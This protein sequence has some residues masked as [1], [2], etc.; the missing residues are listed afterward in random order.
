MT[1]GET[2]MS[3]GH[4]PAAAVSGFLTG[5]FMILGGGSL[6]GFSSILRRYDFESRICFS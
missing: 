3:S 4:G 6:F 5:P 2:V 1:G